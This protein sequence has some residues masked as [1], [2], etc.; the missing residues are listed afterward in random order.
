MSLPSPKPLPLSRL[1]VLDV[2]QVMAGPFC[3][4]LLGDMGA[5]VIKVEPPGTGDQTRRSMG[6]TLKGSDSGGFIALNRNKRSVALNLATEEGRQI[7][8]T[9]VDRADVFVTN[10]RPAALARAGLDYDTRKASNPRLVY[11]HINGYGIEGPDRDRAAYDVGA[12]WSRAGVAAALTP[13]GADLPYQRGGMGDHMAGMA[14]A[15]AVAAALLA[16]ERTGEG[17]L[18]STSLMRIGM[19]MIGWDISMSLRLGIPAIPMSVQ[20]PPNPLINAYTA[21]DGRR[22]WLLGLQADR[23]WPDVLRAIERPEWADDPRYATIEARWQHSA[24]LVADLN[25]IFVARPMADWADVFDREDVWLAPVQHAHEVVDD[26]QAHAA[27]GF[28]DV[29]TEDGPLKAVA[30]PVDFAGTPWAPRSMPP[31]FAQHTEEVLLELGFD[32][33]RIIELK[34]AGAI[35]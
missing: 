17:Q 13:D 11:A 14:A 33:D 7:A 29:P 24:E 25:A 8:A 35:P 28:V 6:F 31:E 32:W 34:D 27:G 16:R 3:C 21:G 4:M 22:F 20:A 23:H 15:G 1:K 5:D 30:S 18:V 12:F 26:P 10:A 2:S 19:Y 9:L